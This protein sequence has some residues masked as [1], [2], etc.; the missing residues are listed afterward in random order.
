MLQSHERGQHSDSSCD[1]NGHHGDNRSDMVIV[2][3]RIIY[4]SVY[5]CDDFE[6]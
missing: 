4:H 6:N 2:I 3:L 1:D 5:D